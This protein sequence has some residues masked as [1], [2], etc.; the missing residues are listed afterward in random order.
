MAVQEFSRAFVLMQYFEY[1][2]RDPS[3]GSDTN[4]DGY[5][6]VRKFDPPVFQRSL[7]SCFEDA[8][9]HISKSTRNAESCLIQK[10][11]LE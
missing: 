9:C 1:L 3:T 7:S 6:F 4:L 10:L 5:N 8:R 11:E 2:H